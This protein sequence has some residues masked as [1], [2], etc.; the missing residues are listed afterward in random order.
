MTGPRPRRLRGLLARLHVPAA[1]RCPGCGKAEQKA[2]AQLGMP[3]RHPERIARSLSRGQ[4]E[5]LTRAAEQLW[6]GEEY[7]AIIAEFLNGG[8]P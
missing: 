8:Q 5:W 4:E 7:A 6:P 3:A 2:R 1:C